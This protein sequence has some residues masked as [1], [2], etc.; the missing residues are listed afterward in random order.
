MY[1]QRWPVQ[2]QHVLAYRAEAEAG[3][4]G[5]ALEAG[6]LRSG[7]AGMGGGAWLC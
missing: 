2:K 5:E 3:V 7:A 6:A 4:E 1:D